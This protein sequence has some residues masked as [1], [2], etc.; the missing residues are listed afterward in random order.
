M[1]DRMKETVV[2][3]LVVTQFISLDGVIEDPAGVEGSPHGA[4]SFRADAPDGLRFK[5]DELMAADAQLLGRA[6][7]ETFAASWPQRRDAAG[8]AERMNSM[9]KYVVSSTLK[10]ATWN[11]T[12]VISLD[13]VAAVKEWHA[14]DIIVPGSARLVHALR[15]RGLVD[16]YRLIVHPV[17]L[18]SGRRLWEGGTTELELVE[19]RAVGPHVVLQVYRPAQW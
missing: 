10:A 11:N 15:E 4:W 13:K 3:K 1:T 18:G 2:G 16:E 7:Y 17:V 14:R 5:L 8:F 6:T 19:C 12:E 9:P